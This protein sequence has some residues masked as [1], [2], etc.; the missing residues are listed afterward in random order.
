MRP[1]PGAQQRKA[2]ERQAH[3][4]R[5][6]T[7]APSRPAVRRQRQPILAA[8]TTNPR[9]HHVKVCATPRC[10]NLTSKGSHCAAH[11]THRPGRP[12]SHAWTLLRARLLADKPVCSICHQRPA[13]T[14]DHIT[15]V[16]R[17]GTD[18]PSNLQPACR[19][20]NARKGN[21]LTPGG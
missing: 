12:S 2:R 1:Q 15:P 18:D 3:E 16:S 20:C 19:A 10:P 13:T 14:I 6:A 21:R 5:T 9:G 4:A 17:G 8:G 7:R 11:T